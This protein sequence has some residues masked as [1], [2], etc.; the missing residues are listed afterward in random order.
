VDLPE[1]LHWGAVRGN[2]TCRWVVRREGEGGGGRGKEEERG[3]GE[4][5]ERG[6]GRRR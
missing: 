4:G 1:H 3:R 6:R 5:E 2:T